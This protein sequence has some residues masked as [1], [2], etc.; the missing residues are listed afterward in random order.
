[1]M[2]KN[3]NS[4]PQEMFE[5]V[6][7]GERIGDVKLDTKPVGYFR[8]AWHRFKKNKASVAAACI[9]LV[10]ALF[11]IIA[12]FCAKFEMSEADGYYAKTR[13]KVD[14]FSN[15]NSGFW[16]GTYTSE[17]SDNGYIYY[18]S[19]AMGAM[20]K[21][22]TGNIS[23]EDAENFELNP[24]R[25]VL[26]TYEQSVAGAG[27][28]TQQFQK[29]RLDSYYELGFIYIEG[30]T[31]QEY[32]NILSWQESTGITVL[33]PMIDEWNSDAFDPFNKNTPIAANMWYAHD[34]RQNPLDA[35]GKIMTLEQVRQKGLTPNYVMKVKEDEN[36]VAITDEH[37]DYVYEVSYF[38]RVGSTGNYKIRVLYYNY[39]QYLNG[40][41]PSHAFGADSQGYDIFIRLAKGIRLSLLLAVCVS[42]INLTIGAIYGAIEGY[43]GGAVDMIM[44]RVTDV[45]SGVPF[46][47]LTSLFKLHFV[48]TGRTSA[49]G[50]L[51]F[52]FVLTGW[53][54]T[55]YS[56]RMQFYR[57]KG[58]EY[59]LA[60]RTLGA[61]DARLMFRHIFPNSLGTLITSSVL[62]IPSVIFSETSL[63]YLGIINFNGLDMTSLGTMLNNGK[64][65]GIDRF[66]HIIFFPAL[67][68]SLLMISFNLFGN[69]LRD[70][71]NPSLRGS[72]G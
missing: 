64:L 60:A 16:D 24:V 22:G 65:A 49:I 13:P 18:W 54:G 59:I 12:L 21:N 57:F 15:T 45:L 33:Y 51:L 8:D 37:G 63:A 53:I 68:I 10:I 27:K 17:Q 34:S 50:G 67:V 39:Y 62:V 70:A 9:I 29:L 23:W 52:V 56:V 47:V 72:E 11:A 71:F 5:M 31:P 32:Q 40:H 26:K 44:E 14:A 46:I 30:I 48:D 66:P 42:I 4:I 3:I 69:G 36:G 41:T 1:M 55:A 25:K 38:T 28:K 2:D 35:N 7:E 6:H 43:Y 19:I 61:K 20:D 58:Q